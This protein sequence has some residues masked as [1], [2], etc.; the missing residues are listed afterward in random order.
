VLVCSGDGVVVLEGHTHWVWA[1]LPL[2]GDILL[3]AGADKCIGK[4]EG[5]KLLQ[6]VDSGHTGSIMGM[7][8]FPGGRRFATCSED[9]MIKSW[10]VGC[11]K[12][13]GT[14]RGHS[15]WIRDTT[16]APGF[17]LISASGDMSLKVWDE[18]GTCIA[19]L[20]GHTGGV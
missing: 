8:L 10:D 11:L 17:G 20:L 7:A 14:L 19:T 6:M 1:I 13:V 5:G 16:F 18:A 12:C 9:K 3:S 2:P 15:G 4:W